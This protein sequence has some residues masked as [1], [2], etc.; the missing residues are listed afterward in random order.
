MGRTCRA[1]GGKMRNVFKILVQIPE[2]INH[3]GE[4]GIDDGMI[5]LKRILGN[6]DGVGGIHLAHDRDRW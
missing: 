5:T 3:S 2:G 6:K 1:Y 4:L